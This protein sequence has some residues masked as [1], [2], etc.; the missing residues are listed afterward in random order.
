MALNEVTIDSVRRNL[1]SDEWALILKENGAERYLPIYV[2]PYQADIIK[3]ELISPKPEYFDLRLETLGAAADID[4]RFTRLESV[5][6]NRFEDNVF[7]AKLIVAFQNNRQEVEC[8]LPHAV[9]IG[10]RTHAPIFVDD[11]VLEQAAFIAGA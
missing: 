8:P 3:R 5:V 1:L 4:I 9:A 6:I 2:G 7:H 11:Q 10:I